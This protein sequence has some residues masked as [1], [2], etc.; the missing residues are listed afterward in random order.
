MDFPVKNKITYASKVEGSKSVSDNSLFIPVPGPKG[1]PGP[2]GKN[3]I[4]GKDG[5]DGKPGPKGERGAP[6]KDGKPYETASGQY[7]GW[8]SYQDLE[9]ST[10]NLG[11]NKGSDGW[12]SLFISKNNISEERYLPKG[13]VS[14]YNPETRTIN[15]KGLNLGSQIQ[16]T[17]EFVIT[18]IHSNTEVWMRSYFK[19]SGYEVTS[20]VANLKYQHEY[21]LSETHN[22]FLSGESDRKSGIIPQIRTDMDAF[23]NLKSIH[24]SAH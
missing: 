14:L 20:F 16:I 1:D 21:L 19:N 2:P 15:L 17:Y 3:G 11:A 12:V 10:V 8:A 24:I 18:T 22:I 9:K 4:D 13:G 6:G 23:A 7:P 5:K